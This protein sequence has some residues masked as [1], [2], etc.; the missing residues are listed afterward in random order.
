MP[1]FSCVARVKEAPGDGD[2][3]NQVV[4]SDDEGRGSRSPLDNTAESL[5]VNTLVDSSTND[6]V[7]IEVNL[8]L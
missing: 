3:D 6:A 2:L 1:N 4:A 7:S 8:V 5:Y